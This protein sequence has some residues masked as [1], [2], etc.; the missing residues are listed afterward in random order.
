MQPIVCRTSPAGNMTR[1]N[2]YI[3]RTTDT[4]SAFFLLFAVMLAGGYAQPTAQVA[5]A[6]AQSSPT[7]VGTGNHRPVPFVSKQQLLIGEAKDFG[8]ASGDDGKS[9]AFL[10]AKDFELSTVAAKADH[11]SQAVVFFAAIAA[12]PY[13]ARAPPA[14]S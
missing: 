8:T 7:D 5:S 11:T 13:E 10:P 2:A 9:K 3:G 6:P 4:L 1:L 12:S 14:I